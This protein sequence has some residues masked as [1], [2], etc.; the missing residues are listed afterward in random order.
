MGKT[1]LA[2][3]QEHLDAVTA[4]TADIHEGRTAQYIPELASVAPDQF[5]IALCTVDG[6]L[7]TAGDGDAEFTLQST[8]KPF[9]YAAALAQFGRHGVRQRVG[10]EPTGEA[11]D[12]F[13]GLEAGRHQP[14]NPMVNMGAIA[15]AGMLAGAGLNSSTDVVAMFQRLAGPDLVDYDRAVFA[16]ERTTGHRNRAIAHLLRQSGVIEVEA[17]V[18]LDRYLEACSTRTTIGGL[19]R[20]AAVLADGGRRPGTRER[21]LPRWVVNDTLAVMS[22]CGM[23]DA[24]G[25]FAFDIGLPAKSGVSGALIAVVPGRFALATFSPRLDAHGTSVRG[26]AALRLI[27]ER[28]DLHPFGMAEGPSRR[29]PSTPAIQQRLDRIVQQRR[30]FGRKPPAQYAPELARADVATTAIALCTTAGVTLAAGDTTQ[31]FPIQAAANPFAY[32]A[33]LEQLGADRIYQH[34]G[35]EPSG[36]H[37]D[38][39]R[40]GVNPVRPFNPMENAGAITIAGLLVRSAPENGR[41]SDALSAF[42]GSTLHL[43]EG[44]LDGEYRAGERNRAIAALLRG[45]GIVEDEESALDR[46]FRQCS[47]TLT[48]VELAR[49]AAVLAGHGIDPISGDRVISARTARDTLAVMYTTGMHE[50]SGEFA[51][52]V[53][54]PSKSGIS[55]CIVAVAPG[56]M[57]VAV[58]SPGIDARG[59]S[60]RGAVMLRDLS[61]ALDLSAF[62]AGSRRSEG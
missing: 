14:H 57:G 33:A 60:M 38:A 16:S 46:Y 8:C 7:L 35:I 29:T 19:A 31:A 6:E 5:G 24:A 36:R 62:S 43:D 50:A 61:R 37:S 39:I 15:V 27:A 3:L 10:V 12:S 28:L 23:Y 9:L 53:G 22:T 25:H 41:V 13:I 40:L 44:M 30:S 34:V 59:F 56:R 52:S 55:G 47:T 45:A 1:A 20:L 51:V 21:A 48:V 54:M 17:E 32:A 26:F 18:A 2:V 4:E 11:F 42:A 49:M 58:Y